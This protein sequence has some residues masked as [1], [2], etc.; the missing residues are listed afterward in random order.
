MK[1]NLPLIVGLTLPFVVIILVLI[2]VYVPSFIAKPQYDFILTDQPRGYYESYGIF[3]EVK[4]GKIVRTEI[5]YPSDVNIYKTAYKEPRLFI[6]RAGADSVEEISFAEVQ[7]KTISTSSKAPDGYE[8]EYNRGN[9]GIFEIFGSSGDYRSIFL[10][11][12]MARTRIS[13]VTMRSNYYSDTR[14]FLG[15]VI[16]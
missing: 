9:N 15:W 8:I 7:G 2:A 11:K 13:L 14:Q 10:T 16:K 4:E 3:Y 6:Y 1:K 5:P 12:G